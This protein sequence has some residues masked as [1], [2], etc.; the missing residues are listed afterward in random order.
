MTLEELEARRKNLE[1]GIALLR[2]QIADAEASLDAMRK[3]LS[4][5]MGAVQECKF[6]IEQ[7]RPSLKIVDKN[8]TNQ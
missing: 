2:M 7:A 1:A 5:T 8:D 3:N 4:A 6:W